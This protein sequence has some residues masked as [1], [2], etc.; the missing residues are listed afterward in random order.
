MEAFVRLRTRE[1]CSLLMK[2]ACK[3]SLLFGAEMLQ[4][5]NSPKERF[6]QWKALVSLITVANPSMQVMS[7]VKFSLI[8]LATK[9]VRICANGTCRQ[10]QSKLR[11]LAPW[12]QLESKL[13]PPTLRFKDQITSSSFKRLSNAWLKIWLHCKINRGTIAELL[14]S[15]SPNSTSYQVSSKESSLTRRWCMMLAQIAARRS[16][17]SLL[18]TDVRT[19]IRFIAQWC[20]PI[21]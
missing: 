15:L 8:H 10:I 19:A 18:V 1:P 3:S 16:K 7:T 5:S 13:M 9:D 14:N 4:S 17:M 21:C 2:L 12:L 11:M 6:L 20:L